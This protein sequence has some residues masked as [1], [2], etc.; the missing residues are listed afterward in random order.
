MTLIFGFSSIKGLE[1]ENEI[2]E[3]VDVDFTVCTNRQCK[4][5]VGS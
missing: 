3:R 1:N 5:W 2:V 4:C